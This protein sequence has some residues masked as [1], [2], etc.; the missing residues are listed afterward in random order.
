MK[1]VLLGIALIV[2]IAGC[3]TYASQEQMDELNARRD[4]VESLKM[5]IKGKQETKAN[6]EEEVTMMEE[7]IAELEEEIAELEE[8]LK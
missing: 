8:K 6:M 7:R 5:E 4:A 3:T 2:L 1:K